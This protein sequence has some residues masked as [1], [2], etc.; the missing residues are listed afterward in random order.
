[1]AEGK[2]YKS[3]NVPG[4]LHELVGILNQDGNWLNKDGSWELI[5]A[6]YS[7]GNYTVAIFKRRETTTWYCG[8]GHTNGCNLAICATCGR[9]PKGELR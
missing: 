4:N 9:D 7:R 8:C 2:Y 5:A 6:D 1:M 3:E